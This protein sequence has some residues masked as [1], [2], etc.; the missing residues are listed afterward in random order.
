MSEIEES[1]VV[2]KAI[3]TRYWCPYCH[4]E[5]SLDEVEWPFL[6]EDEHRDETWVFQ[7]FCMDID[8]ECG[9]I[10][11]VTDLDL[12]FKTAMECTGRHGFQEYIALEEEKLL[13]GL[14]KKEV[15]K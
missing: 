1:E 13:K 9:G 5:F 6:S 15:E 7:L 4:G 8:C 3:V 14:E 12:K 2:E 10:A 11:L